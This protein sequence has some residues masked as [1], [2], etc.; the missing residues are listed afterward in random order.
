VLS[1]PAPTPTAVPTQGRPEPG[2]TA[3]TTYIPPLLAVGAV[4]PAPSCAW[5]L[6]GLQV[7]SLV[8]TRQVLE[9]HHLALAD[10]LRA[11]SA[12]CPWLTWG[13]HPPH[14]STIQRPSRLME[15]GKAATPR[16]RRPPRPT[17]RQALEGRLRKILSKIGISFGWPAIT[18]RPDSSRPR[19]GADLIQAWPS[20]GHHQPGRA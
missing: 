6:R 9:H 7:P 3:T 16:C 14:G 19:I 5:G 17:V 2:L 1:D 13:N 20:K 18:R 10:R 12:V 8:G 11:P 15:R 4:Q